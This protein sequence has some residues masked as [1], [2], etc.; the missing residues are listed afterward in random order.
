MIETETLPPLPVLSPFH[1][2]DPE[3]G[4][5]GGGRGRER[6]RERERKRES[7]RDRE[8]EQERE[9]ESGLENQARATPEQGTVGTEVNE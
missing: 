7:E 5:R 2:K 6:E 3:A 1:I 8:K 4:G 9:R